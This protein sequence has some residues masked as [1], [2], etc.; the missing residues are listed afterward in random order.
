MF[1]ATAISQVSLKFLLFPNALDTFKVQ[2]LI[3]F[4]FSTTVISNLHSVA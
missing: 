4:L 1:I 2:G 3:A